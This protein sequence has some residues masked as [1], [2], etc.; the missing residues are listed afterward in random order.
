MNTLE[1]VIMRILAHE[2]ANTC[3]GAKNKA[4]IVSYVGGLVLGPDMVVVALVHAVH[5]F[6]LRMRG[7]NDNAVRKYIQLPSKHGG[8]KLTSSIC[9][10]P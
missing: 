6:G 8:R 1:V 7:Q 10:V 3:G 5:E 4:Y 9:N 2:V